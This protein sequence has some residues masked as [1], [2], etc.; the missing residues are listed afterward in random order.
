LQG[1]GR[2]LPTHLDW[3]VQAGESDVTY[4]LLLPTVVP[5]LHPAAAAA[6]TCLWTCF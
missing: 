3:M 6:A 4:L 5:P 2:A 1:C